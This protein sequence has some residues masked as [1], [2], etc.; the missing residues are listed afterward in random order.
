MENLLSQT[1]ENEKAT[2]I[3]LTE[4]AESSINEQAAAEWLKPG[5]KPKAAG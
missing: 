2:D 5:Y 4:I 1:L 3:A